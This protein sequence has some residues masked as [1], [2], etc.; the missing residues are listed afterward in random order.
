LRLKIVIGALD[1]LIA[2]SAIGG[3]LAILLRLDKFPLSWLA[4]T[5]FNDYVV[6][7][8]ILTLV[9]GGGSL[10]AVVAIFLKQETSIFV[11]MIAGII[12]VAWISA[13]IGLINAP[14]PSFIEVI[15][16]GL[17]I[18]VLALSSYARLTSFEVEQRKKI[19]NSVSQTQ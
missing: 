19:E 2:V 17:G 14:K 3:G 10:V 13:E 12:M 11:S 5:P 9:V 16:L 18:A 1:S 6:P 8:L 7:A 4:N 15:Y